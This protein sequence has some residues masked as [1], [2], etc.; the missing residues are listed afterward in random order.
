M[1]FAAPRVI[2]V[3][4]KKE[5]LEAIVSSFQR[6][7]TPCVGVKFAV[8]DALEPNHFRGVRC[9]FMD[10]H[11]AGGQ[12]GTD[13][14][15]DFARIQGVLE[16]CISRTGGP[17]ILVM[18]TA[19]PHLKDELISYLDRNI[20]PDL[21]HAR[22]LAVLSLAKE[23][24]L[25]D[26]DDGDV[27]DPQRL[28]DAIKAKVLENPQLAALLEWEAEVQT[29]AGA[30]L[31]SLLDLVP[32]NRR[33]NA[34]FS[35]ALDIILSRLVRETV[36]SSHVDTRPMAAISTALAPILSDLVLNQDVEEEARATWERAVTHYAGRGPGPASEEEAGKINRMLHLAVPGSEVLQPTDWGAVVAW[37]FDWNDATLKQ[38][39][40][41][42]IREMICEEFKLRSSAI[43]RCRPVLVR[44]G[45]ACDYAQ[46]KRGPITYLFGLDIPESAERQRGRDDQPIKAGDA[47]WASPLFL[48]PRA[49]EAS[50]LH[51][52][53]RFPQTHLPAN[54]DGCDVP[55]L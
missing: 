13:H 26:M 32:V 9:L 47:V 44:L 5:H 55:P 35:D 18:W 42:T 22:P 17:F 7:G 30:T 41:L 3:D 53:I 1:M 2:A 23:E 49:R 39:T 21:P 33:T 43:D 34:E 38:F 4:D 52:H 20:D 27:R 19:H 28:L 8:E 14:R 51:A 31:A 16:E 6:M 37:P 40:N 25:A 24:F 12:M 50:R 48:M 46:N 45:A 54:T 29:A 10:L 36:G 15:G 11:L